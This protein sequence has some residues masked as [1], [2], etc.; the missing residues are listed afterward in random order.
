LVPEVA[1]SV[2]TVYDLFGGYQIVDLWFIVRLGTKFGVVLDGFV[3]GSVV[4]ASTAGGQ[5]AG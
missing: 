1:K 5:G 2:F 4:I 3:E